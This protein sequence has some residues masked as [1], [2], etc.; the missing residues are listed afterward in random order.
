M[1]SLV[2]LAVVVAAPIPAAAG[3]CVITGLDPDV[4]TP[5]GA[6]IAKGGGV[7][8]ATVQSGKGT[9]DDA[10]I[11]PAWRWKVGSNYVRPTHTTRAPGLTVYTL[12]AG[13]KLLVN[14]ARTR[15]ADVVAGDDAK[16]LAAPKLSAARDEATLVQQTS[17][18]SFIYHTLELELTERPP[19]DALALVIYGADGVARD[20]LRVDSDRQ[21][22]YS[23]SYAG[24]RC[25]TPVPGRVAS[26]AGDKLTFAWIDSSGRPSAMSA[27]IEAK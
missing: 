16:L 25:A 15:M 10:S 24:N 7:I 12:P 23:L 2:I 20:W 18:V 27:A 8:V 5:T 9:T 6:K 14:D 13:A 21:Q 4:L 11:Q 1:R 17:G 22:H 26:T 3:P 19:D